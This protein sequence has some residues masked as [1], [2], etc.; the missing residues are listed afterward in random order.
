[1]GKVANAGASP[2]EELPGPPPATDQAAP[3][4]SPASE[5]L[6][7]REVLQLPALAGSRLVAG[8]D[9]LD[10]VVR[11][12]NVMEVP[13]IQPWVKPH[14]LLLTTGYPLRA[15]PERLT[16][17][18]ADLDELGL[19][20]LAVKLHR[21]LTALPAEMLAEADRRALP[22]I[23]LSDEVG[24][25]DILNQ[26]LTGILNRQTAVLERSEQ[27]HRALVSSV[28]TG[29]GLDQLVEEVANM[30]G[31]VTLVTTP[32]G[33]VL[34]AAGPAGELATWSASTAFDA[35][36]RFRTERAGRGISRMDGQSGSC[37]VVP[38]IAGQVDHGRLV[39][40]HPQRLLGAGDVH[41]LERAATV[42]ALAVTKELAVTAVENK[43]R[44][45][46][47]R[48][49]LVGRAGERDD[50][51][52]HCQALGWSVLRRMVV[53][54][55]ALD[56]PSNGAPR[57]GGATRPAQERFSAAWQN[58]LSRL[59]P[60]APVVGFAQEVVAL[61]GVPGGVDP[62]TVVER[63][64]KAVAGDGGGGRRPFA[65]GVSRVLVGV[66]RLPEAYE[67]ACKAVQ[68]GRL[69]QGAS[70]VAHFDELGVFRLLSLIP[71]PA[72]L[73]A[74][75]AEVL[76]PLADEADLEAADLRR[77]L[78]VLLDT[79]LNVA[80]AAR[81]LHFHY[82]TLRYRIAKLERLVGPF[83]R[84][85]RLRLDLA[86]ALRVLEMRGLGAGPGPAR[87]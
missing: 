32:D 35:S 69:L 10:R 21:Y 17:L 12:A 11:R 80:E 54:V 67:Q 33:R 47:L 37:A 30:R 36:G 60:A 6:T 2:R 55:A 58:V 25:D 34:A 13:D 63:A 28:L 16:G 72:D 15:Q 66:D 3:D 45:D 85:P 1:M 49:V 18:V 22:V 64:V 81:A 53:V 46:F 23:L 42:A 71:D 27:V 20:A 56:P 4:A 8:R 39:A 68:V 26:A 9:G 41:V 76:G 43:Y 59:D 48:D 61:L 19:A 5:G 73:R 74:F 87:R 7:V 52:A 83:A 38:V 75:V 50:V 65:T 57:V 14:Q 78:Q 40:F 24:F 79:N 82:N 51:V 84:D 86:L 44:G 77:T 70:A 31:G 29:G 62:P